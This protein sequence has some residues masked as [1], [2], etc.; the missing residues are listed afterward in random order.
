MPR[1]IRLFR[2]LC[3]IR[4]VRR[5]R[6]VGRRIITFCKL[7]LVPGP[8]LRVGS[9]FKLVV[10]PL[11]VVGNGVKVRPPLACNS[12]LRRYLDVFCY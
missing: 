12:L 1:F 3:N 8:M 4:P 10:Q 7:R 11:Q 9:V 2:T 6:H 5:P